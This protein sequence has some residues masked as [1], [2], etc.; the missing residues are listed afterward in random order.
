MPRSQGCR[1]RSQRPSRRF[2]CLR[3]PR[4][5]EWGGGAGRSGGTSRV[6]HLHSTNPHAGNFAA[7]EIATVPK[8]LSGPFV[9]TNLK[10]KNIY[11]PQI[12]APS[13][14]DQRSE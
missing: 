4:D 11:L 14:F 13:V 12:E 1:G 8:E 5:L 9:L 10:G 3:G 6:A 2:G 7:S